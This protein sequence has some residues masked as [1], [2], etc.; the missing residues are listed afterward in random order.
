MR[1]FNKIKLTQLDRNQMELKKKE[2]FAI[3]G[4]NGSCVCV[5]AGAYLPEADNPIGTHLNTAY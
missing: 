3:K 4:A 1:K 2:M 5:C